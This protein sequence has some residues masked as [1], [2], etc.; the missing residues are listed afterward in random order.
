MAEGQEQAA[1]RAQPSRLP[2]LAGAAAV[3]AVAL[4]IL[5]LARSFLW[6][7]V[8]ADER[9][10]IGPG[11]TAHHCFAFDEP[12]RMTVHADTEGG[13]AVAVGIVP[14]EAVDAIGAGGMATRTV[15]G[16]Y[17]A[18]LTAGR[19]DVRVDAD[20]DYCVVV[21]GGPSSRGVRLRIETLRRLW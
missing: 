10:A 7:T 2:A 9:H 8:W 3:G 1:P 15:A 11:E 13:G 19:M 18:S 12:L 21:Q 20:R 5:L 16:G 4:L 17:A 6:P 14:M